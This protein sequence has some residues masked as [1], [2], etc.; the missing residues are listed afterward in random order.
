MT[1][2]TW[3][4]V[5]QIAQELRDKSIA[6]VEPTVP[7]VP[8]ELPLNVSKIPAELL[9]NA[10]IGITETSP[11]NLLASLASGKLTSVEV[12][13]AFLR[14]A[15]LAQK[16]TNCVTELLPSA[17]LTR[18]G[19][20]DDYLA[21]HKKPIGPLHGLPI[22]VKEHI[23]M[24]GLGLNGGFISWWDHKG[25][26]DAFILKLLWKAG[27]VFYVRTTQPQTLM[28]L[29]TSN[30][31][32][33]ETVCP[34]NRTLTSGGSSGGEGALLGLRGS[35]LGI[36]TDIGGSIRSP[37]ANNGLYGFRP[38][39]YRLPC[40]GFT[41]TMMGE[42]HIVPVVGPLSTSLQGC[43]IFLKTLIDQK[44][45]LHEPSL[46]PFL[47][48]D[49]TSYLTTSDGK[50]RLKIGVLWDDGVV[51]PHPPITRALKE[52][53]EKLKGVPEVELLDWKPYKH[54]YA[55]DVISSLYFADGAKEEKEAIEASGEPWRPLSHYIITEQP[56]C[57]EL[58]VPEVWKW[59]VKR[60]MYRAEYGEVW[61]KT[62]AEDD[63]ESAVDVIL[64]PVGPGAAPPLNNA[65][66][67]G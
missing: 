28:H 18:A 4:E 59:T 2:K 11:E 33:G 37:A 67:W 26:D 7:D 49:D 32:Y 56:M 42:E 41:A 48:R 23:G 9:S 6:E 14:R 54:D 43:K 66:Y 31:L 15:A 30:N 61:N 1:A 22:S 39:S 55:W 19:Y 60:E 29:E 50:K 8:S 13:N 65:R 10:E 47:W 44:P 45:W 5:A 57:K 40:G 53:C 36:G 51:K 20:L 34:F 3:Q 24:K 12:T 27:A 64:C 25:E 62:A 63:A 35:C 21:T 17:A 46:L 38:T 58:T 52:V 16:L